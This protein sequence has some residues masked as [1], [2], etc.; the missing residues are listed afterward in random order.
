MAFGH[1]PWTSPPAAVRPWTQTQPLLAAQTG[2]TY[3]LRWQVALAGSSH[4]AAPRHALVSSSPLFIMHKPFRFSPISQ[5][6]VC[7]WL[8]VQVGHVTSGPL[9]AFHLPMQHVTDGLHPSFPKLRL[10]FICTVCTYRNVCA[11]HAR[12]A[13]VGSKKGVGSLWSWNYR[14]V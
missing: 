4:Q 5:P 8:P 6:H 13:C 3:G 10:Y 12:S 11:P 1:E 9:S 7:T 2:G 14:L